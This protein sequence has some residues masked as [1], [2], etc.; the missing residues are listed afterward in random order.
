MDRWGNIKAPAGTPE[1]L[2]ELAKAVR[3]LQDS[4]S[5]KRAFE[6][7]KEEY[8]LEKNVPSLRALMP[9]LDAWKRED[10]Y[11]TLDYH[12]KKG[13]I[14]GIPEETN[15]KKFIEQKLKE[16]GNFF[17]DGYDSPAKQQDLEF[18]HKEAVVEHAFGAAPEHVYP[19]ESKEHTGNKEHIDTIE[20]SLEDIAEELESLECFVDG[21]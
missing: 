15:D 19:D 11:H 12:L 16:L 9:V 18:I 5:G 4:F 20:N 17:Q 13:F 1:K 7:E 14:D 2:W 21:R 6:Y 10:F 8:Y 3:A